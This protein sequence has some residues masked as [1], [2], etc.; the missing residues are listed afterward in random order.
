MP[1]ARFLPA[2]HPLLAPCPLPAP[3]PPLAPLTLE[4]LLAVAAPGLL[5][6]A[7]VS[8]VQDLLEALHAQGLVQV[9]LL[10]LLVPEGR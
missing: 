9:L 1:P 2:P 7:G 4:V 8:V 10:L 3:R 5:G 6:V